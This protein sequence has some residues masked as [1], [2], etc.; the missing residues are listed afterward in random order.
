MGVVITTLSGAIFEMG[1]VAIFFSAVQ[2]LGVVCLK[3]MREKKGSQ[4]ELSLLILLA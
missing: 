1:V 4:W 3:A 2:N